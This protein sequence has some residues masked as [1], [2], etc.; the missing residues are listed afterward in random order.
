MKKKKSVSFSTSPTLGSPLD[1][2]DDTY[3]PRHPHP[4]LK[5]CF[6]SHNCR[7]NSTLTTSVG[8]PCLHQQI[9]KCLLSKYGTLLMKTWKPTETWKDCKCLNM[10]T[11][12]F[13]RVCC[14]I[15]NRDEQEPTKSNVVLLSPCFYLRPWIKMHYEDKFKIKAHWQAHKNHLNAKYVVPTIQKFCQN[16]SSPNSHH[17]MNN[18]TEYY[19]H[20][21]L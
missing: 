14:V 13:L 21:K 4:I 19:I 2:E 3:L 6:S 18:F 5:Y 12:C 20:R 16:L 10:F 7:R 8:S 17:T 15:L 11:W 9:W 1:L